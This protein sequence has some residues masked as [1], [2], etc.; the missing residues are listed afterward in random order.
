MI[1][2]CLSFYSPGRSAPTKLVLNLLSI[3]C[4]AG[5]LRGQHI[6]TTPAAITPSARQMAYPVKDGVMFSALHT[7]YPLGQLSLPE[8][9]AP[10]FLTF[11]PS[12]TRLLASGQS[13]STYI[14]QLNLPTF[15]QEAKLPLRTVAA[16]FNHAG[17]TAYLLQRQSFIDSKLVMYDTGSWKKRR[18]Q[19]LTAVSPHL[20]LNA[21]DSLIAFSVLGKIKIMNAQSLKIAQVLWER[22]PQKLVEF[23]PVSPTMY[24]ST[25]TKNIIQIRDL[26]NDSILVEIKKHNAP[27]QTL[28]YR[29]DGKYLFSLD[30]KGNLYVWSLTEKTL[31][32]E[33]DHVQGTPYWDQDGALRIADTPGDSLS[34]PAPQQVALQTIPGGDLHF[35]RYQAPMLE[36]FPSP[37]IGYSPEAGFILG[38]G[39]TAIEQPMGT[40]PYYRPSLLTA[41]ASHG[42]GGKQ[43]LL[44]FSLSK[45]LKERWYIAA[46]LQYNIHAKSYYFGIGKDAGRENKQPYIADNFLLSGGVYRLLGQQLGLGI[47][48]DIRHNKRAR[49][50]KDLTKIPAGVEGGWT[51]GLGAG[52]RLDSRDNILAPSK[53]AFLQLTYLYYGLADV[54][55]Y[56]YHEI[57]ADLRKYFPLGNPANG[58]QIAVQGAADITWNGQPPFY[59]LPYFTADKALRGIYRNLYIDR[60]VAFA[61][62]EYRSR[63]N[64]ADPRFGYTIFAGAADGAADFLHDYQSD[65]KAV[66]GLGFRQQLYPKNHLLLRMDAAWTSKGDFGF[67]AS[68]GASF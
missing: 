8:H 49:F 43:W 6:V 53:G 25:T 21:N 20:S 41:S 28:S 42:F 40:S 63:F 13:A 54:G 37:I 66:Y 9:Q 18:Q 5:P 61:Q 17:T 38:L 44:E 22:A 55:D 59:M 39:F 45:Y 64:V 23:D 27:I 2:R 15:Q 10:T 32:A 48:Y 29:P 57:K 3:L 67:F 56:R 33:R 34:A 1:N 24:A 52:L 7:G 14:Y 19:T 16:G 35:H 11:D 50:E 58:R 36:V 4:W 60:Q 68:L 31:L 46:D 51:A 12:G 47:V 30:K 62:V 65:I 26:R